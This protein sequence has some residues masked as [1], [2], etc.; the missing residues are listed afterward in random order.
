MLVDQGGEDVDVG[1]YFK[2][3]RGP[4]YQHYYFIVIIKI[5]ILCVLLF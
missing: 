3:S 2:K 4:I 5:F 1:T